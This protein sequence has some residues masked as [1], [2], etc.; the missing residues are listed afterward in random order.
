MK[1]EDISAQEL[2]T[3]KAFVA[4]REEFESNKGGYEASYQFVPQ[5][6]PSCGHCPT[7]GRGG[8]HTY[9]YNPWGYPV[10]GTS[11]STFDPNMPIKV[12]F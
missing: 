2:A 10:W 3:M 11:T 6:C 9:P 7:C 1:S 12:T 5:P 4:S 8:F